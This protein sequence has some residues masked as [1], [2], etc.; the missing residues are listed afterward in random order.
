[1]NTTASGRPSPRSVLL[2]AG[3]AGACWFLAVAAAGVTL[4][5]FLN[6]HDGHGVVVIGAIAFSL[7]T[8]VALGV[9]TTLGMIA[10]SRLRRLLAPV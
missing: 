2:L 3:I 10:S 1:M 7:V 6:R 9:A 4:L 5:F 8:L